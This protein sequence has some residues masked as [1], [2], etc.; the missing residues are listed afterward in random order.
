MRT[1][2]QASLEFLTTYVWA[3]FVIAITVGTL[4]YFGIF[5]FGKYL[6]QKCVFTSQFKCL[7]FS[8]APAEVRIKLVNNLLENIKVTAVQITNDATPPISCTPPAVPFDWAHSA[9]RDIVFASCG[10]GAYIAGE[11]AELKV[12]ISYYA[13]DTPSRPVHLINGKV[14]GKVTSS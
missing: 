2:S 13:V 12:S 4:Y 10:G 5:D 9:E 8:L 3:F 14:N 6:P 11:R 7:D 1:K